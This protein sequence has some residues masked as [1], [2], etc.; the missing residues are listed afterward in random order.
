MTPLLLSTCCCHWLPTCP[1]HKSHIYPPTNQLPTHPP[2]HPSTNYPSIHPLTHNQLLTHPP[3]QPTTH[4]LPTC[5]SCVLYGAQL[6]CHCIAP[7]PGTRTLWIGVYSML[8][9]VPTHHTEK[10]S[11]STPEGNDYSLWTERVMIMVS[12][13][14]YIWRSRSILSHDVMHQKH[15]LELLSAGFCC[16]LG[17]ALDAPQSPSNA[18]LQITPFKILLS[19]LW[20]YLESHLLMLALVIALH[21]AQLK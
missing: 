3:H 1:P 15:P 7:V 6:D 10:R 12:E 11:H 20:L 19:H 16:Y 8:L 2:T 17:A 4:L 9:Q 13:K 14:K 18:V 21:T 5:Y